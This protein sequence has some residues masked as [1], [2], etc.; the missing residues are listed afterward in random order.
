MADIK[1]TINKNNLWECL[2]E[3]KLSSCLLGG[4]NY[5]LSLKH[6][7]NISLAITCFFHVSL[8]WHH[9]LTWERRCSLRP[10]GSCSYHKR[11]WF[12]LK[13]SIMTLSPS[14]TN[15]SLHKLKLKRS[16]EE[17]KW[18]WQWFSFH[19]N[20]IITFANSSADVEISK[21]ISTHE[22]YFA[23]HSRNSINF[24]H[25]SHINHGIHDFD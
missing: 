22:V 15:P 13:H 1:P 16:Q 17:R 11:T 20:L 6:N 21:S 12:D 18:Q 4:P 7:H 3:K 5:E 10:R 24:S 2:W 8:F 19:H 9:S 14:K 23:I 25:W